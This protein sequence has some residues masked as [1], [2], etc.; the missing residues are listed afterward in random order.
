MARFTGRVAVVTGGGRGIGEA[1]VMAFAAEGGSVVVADVNA[2]DAARVVAA[3]DAPGRVV[4]AVVDVADRAAVDA[5]M[6]QARARFGRL[7]ILAN[8][9]GI[10]GVA[11][12]IDVAPEQWRRVHAVNLEGTLHT[13][14]AFA[15]IVRA[16]GGRGAIVNLSSMGGIMGV[17]NRAAYV[18]SKHAVTG[19]TREMAMEAGKYGIRVNAIAPGMIRTP[20]TEPM[21]QDPDEVRRIEAVHPVGRAGEPAEIAAA[22]LFLSS[23]EAAFITGVILPVDGGWSAGKGW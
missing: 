11:A 3:C 4:A 9:A 22:I 14:Q 12:V 16:D 21:F 2:D 13:M 19:L 20:M 8:C 7:D 17:P 18:S 1:T 23:D 10:R 6:A 15:R 5:M